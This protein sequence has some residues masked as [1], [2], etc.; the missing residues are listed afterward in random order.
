M[1][2]SACT[3]SLWCFCITVARCGSRQR[4]RRKVTHAVCAARSQLLATGDYE[5]R[6]TVWNL[7]SGEKRMSLFHR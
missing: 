5:G 4:A 3:L 7:F 2:G 6:I 1:D